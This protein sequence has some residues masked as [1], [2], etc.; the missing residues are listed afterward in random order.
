[1]SEWM[2]VFPLAEMFPAGGSQKPQVRPFTKKLLWGSMLQ[3]MTGF[4]QELTQNWTQQSQKTT[5]KWT[6]KWK[7]G[8]CT[9]WPRL[10]TSWRC[11]RAAKTY[12]L[13]RQNLTLKSNSRLPWD[14]FRTPKRLSKHCGHSFNMMVWLHSN[15]QKDLLCHHLCLQRTF[16]VDELKYEMSAKREESTV[17]QSKAMR[18]VH[19]KPFQILKIGLNGMGTSIIQ[20]TVKTIGRRMLNLI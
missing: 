7:K 16:L 14:R 1:M 17:I 18:I 5:R 10:T 2:P 15:C 13:P 9:E 20:M 12:V 6:K 4:W 8:N 11:G 19:L 3:T